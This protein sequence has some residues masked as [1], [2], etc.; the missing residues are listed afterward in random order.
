MEGDA[1][2]YNWEMRRYRMLEVW[3]GWVGSVNRVTGAGMVP[4][5]GKQGPVAAEARAAVASEAVAA[6]FGDSGSSQ[7]AA[8]EVAEPNEGHGP[9]AGCGSEEVLQ[10][11]ALTSTSRACSRSASALTSR[12][13]PSSV[14]AHASSGVF[15]LM[16]S[17]LSTSLKRAKRTASSLSANLPITRMSGPSQPPPRVFERTGGDLL[18]GSQAGRGSQAFGVRSGVGRV[19]AKG[20]VRDVGLGLS[21]CAGGALRMWRCLRWCVPGYGLDRVRAELLAHHEQ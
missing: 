8:V 15:T 7:H 14:D 9:I 19:R 3:T 6:S 4:P 16:N 17:H 13:A 12:P 1:L 2:M 11:A 5:C 18:W 10:R 20:S 21:P